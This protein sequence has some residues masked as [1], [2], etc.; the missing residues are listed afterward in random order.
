M[1]YLGLVL[2]GLRIVLISLGVFAAV[3]MILL[4]T[5]M[6]A[7]YPPLRTYDYALTD[8]ELYMQLSNVVSKSH[9]WILM[10]TDSTGSIDDRRYHC[11]LIKRTATDSL[12]FTLYYEDVNHWFDRKTK[13]EISLVRAWDNI[14]WTGGYKLD[15]PQVKTLVDLF[16]KEIVKDLE[17]NTS[18]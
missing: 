10:M 15:D 4:F 9:D 1:K 14:L 7:T 12:T 18:R 5:Q 16:E 13:S 8:D 3:Y 6:S 11:K 17:S 2:K